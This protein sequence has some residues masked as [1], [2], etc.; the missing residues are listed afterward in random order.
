[1]E[2]GDDDDRTCVFGWTFVDD[3][4]GAETFDDFVNGLRSD[5]LRSGAGPGR[6]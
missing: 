6:T 3:G 2:F 1:V 5:P 4:Q